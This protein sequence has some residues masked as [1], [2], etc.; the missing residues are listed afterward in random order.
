[1]RD[2]FALYVIVQLYLLLSLLFYLFN[3]S[4]RK[5][6]PTPSW[7]VAT[8][9]RDIQEAIDDTPIGGT[10]HIPPGVYKLKESLKVGKIMTLRG[11][12]ANRP[13]LIVQKRG[14]ELTGEGC[15]MANLKVC[16]A[17]KRVYP[18]EPKRPPNDGLNGLKRQ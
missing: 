15:V 3:A 4:Q 8:H 10:T 11:E 13:L 17:E 12:T 6:W 16:G 1:M 18:S 9:Y 2:L 14:I 7:M 5:N